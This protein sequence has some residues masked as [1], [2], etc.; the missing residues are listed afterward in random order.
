MFGFQAENFHLESK[1]Q[2][3][4]LKKRFS[5]QSIFFVFLEEFQVFLKIDRKDRSVGVSV[6]REKSKISVHLFRFN[7]GTSPR[8]SSWL[9]QRPCFPSSDHL[10]VSIDV[11]V[12]TSPYFLSLKLDQT[13]AHELDWTRAHELGLILS[14]REANVEPHVVLVSFWA[15][16]WCSNSQ[17]SSKL[18][19][20][21][22]S[23]RSS[24]RFE[25]LHILVLVLL[26]AS[27]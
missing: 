17:R 10:I 6:D 24:R 8:S 14:V 1:Q 22:K 23:Q 2:R 15:V 4:I 26:T 25:L 13:R 3:N 18:I 7:V 12:P 16:R 9:W 27:L 11:G 5:V 20:L 21:G 19:E